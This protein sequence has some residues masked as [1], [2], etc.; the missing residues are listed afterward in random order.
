MKT[1]KKFI[2]AIVVLSIV[3]AAISCKKDETQQGADS[4]FKV[5]FFIGD[6][7]ILKEQ[8][9]VP[10]N[11]GDSLNI[12][13]TIVTGARSYVDVLYASAGIIRIGENSTVSVAAITDNENDDTTLNMEKGKVVVTLSKLRKGN[14]NVKTHTVIAAVRGTSF[15]VESGD[16][17]TKLAVLK[18]TVSA[19]PVKKDG[20]VIEDKAVDVQ[21]SFK[22]DFIN[23]ALVDKIATED[24]TIAVSKM[25][26]AETTE[27]QNEALEIREAID[28]IQDISP[29]EKESIKEEIPVAAAANTNTNEKARADAAKK[30]ADQLAADAAK[31]EAA[32][33]QQAAAAIQQQQEAAKK[34]KEEQTKKERISNIPTM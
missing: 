7:K 5:Q 14:F 17:G 30:K 10:A 31:R 16:T 19:R 9:N 15:S 18:G 25:T 20:S 34:A 23:E 8:E 28:K 33:K 22:T 24:K 26:A 4:P 27:F 21:E 3:F 12:D 32:K 13:D 1:A 2:N 6:V 29:Y 11:Q